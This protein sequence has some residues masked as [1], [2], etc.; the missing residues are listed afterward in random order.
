MKFLGYALKKLYQLDY[1]ELDLFENNLGLN[2]NNLK[3]LSL[4]F[5]NV[6]YLK[7]LKLNLSF[8]KLGE[9]EENM[10]YLGDGLK[11]LS[12]NL[13]HFQLNLT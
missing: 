13:H 1:L 7:Q 2:A 12:D 3:M 10:K 9:N 8:N 4:S 11:K 6:Q 5:I